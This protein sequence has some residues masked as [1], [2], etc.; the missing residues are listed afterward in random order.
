MNEAKKRKVNAKMAHALRAATKYGVVA[1]GMDCTFA[2]HDKMR[3][4]GLIA[5]RGPGADV[6]TDKGNQALKDGFYMVESIGEQLIDQVLDGAH[7][8]DVL[9]D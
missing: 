7:P 8:S 4:A 1:G 3:K 5:S 6:I 9:N 2:L